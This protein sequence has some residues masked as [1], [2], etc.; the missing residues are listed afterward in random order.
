MENGGCPHLF[1]EYFHAN[2]I[3]IHKKG[4]LFTLGIEFEE[5]KKKGIRKKSVALLNLSALIQNVASEPRL[6]TLNK[7]RGVRVKSSPLCYGSPQIP[8]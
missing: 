4:Y 1:L 8:T 3:F 5:K 6:A 2:F 7:F